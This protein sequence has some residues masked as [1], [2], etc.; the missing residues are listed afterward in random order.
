[1]ATTNIYYTNFFQEPAID[2][3]AALLDHVTRDH[4]KKHNAVCVIENI[5]EEYIKYL[6]ADNFIDPNFFSEHKRCIS[7]KKFWARSNDWDGNS[8]LPTTGHID[9]MF[10]YHEL[11]CRNPSDLNSGP[12]F[13]KREC[14]KEDRY[15]IQSHTRIS[16]C[17][18]NDSTCMYKAYSVK[19][20]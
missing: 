17:L 19:R 4:M 9:G 16:Y 7:R 3:A 1:M 6:T 14:F 13:I 18:I 12:N 5:S 8:Y 2:S 20:C 11:E 15:G 10:E